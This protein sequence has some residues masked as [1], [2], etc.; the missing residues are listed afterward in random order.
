MEKFF[1]MVYY[2]TR[3]S[4]K[5]TGP[6]DSTR[7]TIQDFAQDMDSL[8]IYLRQP[9]VWVMGHSSGGYQVLY[10]GAHYSDR[11]NG[12]VAI[13]AF[14]GGD[15]LYE[16]AFM[17]N[18][19]KRKEQPFFARGAAIFTG[20]D[21]SHYSLKD[22]M[23]I[24]IPFYFHDTT[25]IERLWSFVDINDPSAFSDRAAKYT[26]ISG[27]D[28]KSLFSDLGKIKVPVLVIVGDD[29]FNC[30]KVT[31]ADRAVERISLA[32]EIVIKNAGHFPWVEE[33]QQF[34]SLSGKWFIAQKLGTR[35]Y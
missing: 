4:G 7:Y 26:A 28:S 25:K 14:V 35:R 33:P 15:S 19:M 32:T 16:A 2:D 34:F 5:S 21:T 27:F 18:M 1:T 31:Q 13:D 9:K 30:D 8:R 12:I 29:D 24:I 22:Q 20:K 6:G 3:I 23:M 11:L 17:Q 10:Y